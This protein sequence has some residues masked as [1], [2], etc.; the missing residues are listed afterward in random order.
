M[1]KKIA[2]RYIW[3]D[4]GEP[5]GLRA[6]TR[7]ITKEEAFPEW[8]FDGSSTW[9]ALGDFS[10][11]VLKPVYHSPDPI[12]GYGSQL[13]LCEVQTLKGEPHAT[14]TR[15]N[16]MDT[17]VGASHLDAWVGFEQEFVLMKD[18]KPIGWP[19]GY[20]TY[21]AP[22]GES[23]C[24]VGASKVSGREIVEEH[25]QACMDAGLAIC[26]INLEVMKGQSE[27]QIGGPG[28]NILEACDQ[29]W[30][31]RFLLELVAERHGADVS[32]DAKPI[33]GDWNGS[34]M[35]TNFST[36]KM[37]EEGGMDEIH[38]VLN[39]MSSE[40]SCKRHLAAYGTGIEDR[41]TG[42]HETCSWEEFKYGVSDRTASVRI[43]YNSFVQKRGYFEDRRPNAN[44]DPYRVAKALLDTTMME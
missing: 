34:G 21:P 26:G 25:L 15:Q 44:A 11:C 42:S 17:L 9:Q 5:Q 12:R 40:E 4:G 35:H 1:S 10:Q 24:G 39:L 28:L 16:L 20:G 32:W 43:P 6:K 37:R 19:E 18:G 27:F 41:L 3:L 7:V 8:G 33:K 14:N 23:Y 30:L 38:R 31:A 22:Q 2:C 13:V 29:L 36:K